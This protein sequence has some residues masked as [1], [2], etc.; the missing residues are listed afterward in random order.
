MQYIEFYSVLFKAYKKE[1]EE[2][3]SKYEYKTYP[4]LSGIIDTYLL[5]VNEDDIDFVLLKG[6]I[7]KANRVF[8][9]NKAEYIMRTFP[10]PYVGYDLKEKLNPSKEFVHE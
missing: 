8:L 3:K 7:V 4:Y 9:D 5:I 10:F 6:E 2:N 1:V